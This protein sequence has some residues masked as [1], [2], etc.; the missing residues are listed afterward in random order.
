M[1]ARYT[2]LDAVNLC[3]RALGEQPTPSLD[4][5]YPTLDLVQ[6]AIDDALLEVQKEG[7][8]FNKFEHYPMEPNATTGLIEVPFDTLKFY[9]DCPERHVWVGRYV[10]NVDGTREIT[11]RVTGTRVVLMPFEDIPVVAQMAVMNLAASKVYRGDAG[12]NNI[13]QSVY[14]DHL[15]MLRELSAD[16]TRTRK[17]NSRTKRQMRIWRWSRIT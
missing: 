3:L 2:R 14:Q 17:Y 6:P 10:A 11:E 8:W 1:D 4:L 13:Y 16:H 5:Q 15:L 9:P 12:I 7:W